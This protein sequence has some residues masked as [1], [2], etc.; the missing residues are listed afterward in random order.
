MVA[1][2][3]TLARVTVQVVQAYG[4]PGIFLLGLSLFIYE[5]IA[6]DIFILGEIAT[7]LVP[8]WVAVSALL[9]TTVGVTLG[10]YAGRL[11]NKWGLRRV[12]QNK[13]FGKIED[14]Y[15]KYGVWIG[16]L[17]ALSPLPLREISWFAGIF[18]LSL[19]QFVLAV[20]LGLVPRYFAEAFLGKALLHWLHR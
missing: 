18:R 20:F 7:G 9:G 15:Q 10:Y 2:F 5:P 6:P 1:F 8:F 19:P 13:Y 3:H 16:F 17:G 4:Y 11:L 14:W 12:R